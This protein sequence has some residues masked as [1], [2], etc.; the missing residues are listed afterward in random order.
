MIR[1]LVGQ[2][3]SSIAC[4]VMATFLPRVVI[5]SLRGVLELAGLSLRS[6]TL[7]PIAALQMVVPEEMRRLNVALEKGRTRYN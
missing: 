6:L 4:E 3:G 7:E 5:D 1:N 2:R